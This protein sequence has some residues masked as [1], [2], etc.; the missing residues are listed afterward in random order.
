VPK[1]RTRTRKGKK[2]PKTTPKK[3]TTAKIKSKK[4]TTAKTKPKKSKAKKKPKACPVPKQKKGKKGQ[5]A[6]SGG[7]GSTTKNKFV[8]DTEDFVPLPHVGKRMLH[9]LAGKGKGKGKAPAGGGESTSA[10]ISAKLMC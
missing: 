6:V 10:D 9:R 5:T 2:R 3:G 1:T 7:T 8:R 4:G